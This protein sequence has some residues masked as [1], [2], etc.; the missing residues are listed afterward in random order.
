MLHKGTSTN[1]VATDVEGPSDWS[2]PPPKRRSLSPE[3]NSPGVIPTSSARLRSGAIF[4]PTT[5][6]NNGK[7]RQ[8]EPPVIEGMKFPQ[9]GTKNS[10][11][12]ILVNPTKGPS[13]GTSAKNKSRRRTQTTSQTIRHSLSPEFTQEIQ[14]PDQPVTTKSLYAT[15][16]SDDYNRRRK[17]SQAVLPSPIN[18]TLRSRSTRSPST[19]SPWWKFELWSP[20]RTPNRQS[21]TPETS[22]RRRHRR[23]H[24]KEA[25]RED[26]PYF[27]SVVVF[28]NP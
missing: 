28:S 7:D 23:R 9:H 21:K 22:E 27:V 15:I 12:S 3:E 6:R 8:L 10:G 18:S 26:T 13:H 24:R 2:E 16:E 5:S 20:P 11:D 14:Q 1:S 19:V 17:K 4:R 25:S